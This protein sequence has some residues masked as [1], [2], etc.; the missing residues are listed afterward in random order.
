MKY[1]VVS[2][3]KAIQESYEAMR[4]KGMEHRGAEMLALQSPPGAMTDVAFFQGHKRL[5][6]EL[7]ERQMKAMKKELKRQKFR[8]NSTDVYVPGL[9]RFQWDKEAFVPAS[10]G[11]GY[12]KKL[13]E[14][15]GWACHGAVEV[16][17]RKDEPKPDKVMSEAL[18]SQN[19]VRHIE[20]NPD[21]AR[22]PKREL[23]EMVIEKHSFKGK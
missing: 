8:P 23:R 2:P 4:K 6:D 20:K 21:L 1:P 11:R 16:K 22:K 12:V 5:G 15:R 17:G 7:S 19:I 3:H 13:C 18:I 14:S 9:A 10:G